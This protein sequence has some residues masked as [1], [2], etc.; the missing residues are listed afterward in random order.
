MAIAKHIENIVRV[1]GT[2]LDADKSIVM[3]LSKIK[4][5]GYPLSKCILHVISLKEETKLKD[6]GDD[7]IKEIEKVIENPI[8]A[9][10]PSWAINR[11][12]DYVSGD[13]M[14]LTGADL[15]ITLRDDI[16]RLKKIRAYRGIRHER[17][18]PTRGQRTRS[19]FRGGASLG[20]SRKKEDTSKAKAKKVQ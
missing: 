9:G 1:A 16:N 5:V 13:D 12:K 19:S 10:I 3:A 14:H 17:G 6:I 11:Q 7:K 18:L 15:Q 2:D 8:A 4:G 20:V